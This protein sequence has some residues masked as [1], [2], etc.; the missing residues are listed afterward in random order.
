MG[1]GALHVRLGA[2]DVQQ[3]AQ[4]T[5]GARARVAVEQRRGERLQQ[6]VLEVGLA[7]LQPHRHLR[8]R[9]AVLGPR[10]AQPGE[11][12]E[13]LPRE[14]VA[15]AAPHRLYLSAPQRPP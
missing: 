12:D 11:L 1:P 15:R 9:A 10:A 7:L 6:V 13:L 14:P 2:R 4:L 5:V 3:E 8:E